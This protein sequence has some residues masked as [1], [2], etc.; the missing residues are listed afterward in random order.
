M[1]VLYITFRLIKWIYNNKTLRVLSISLIA[2][3]IVAKIIN[4]HF[5]K[6]MEFIQSEVYPHLYLIKNPVKD[7][8]LLKKAIK[9]MVVEKMNAEFIG[10]EEKYKR[11]YHYANKS[12]TELNYGFSFMEY[13]KGWGFNPIGEAGTAHFIKN[14]ED[15]GGFSSEYL[16]YYRERFQIGGMRVNYC[17]N[18]TIN[19]TAVL[20]YSEN[21]YVVERDTLINQCK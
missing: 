16:E 21:G 14:K 13:Y 4:N 15:P 9:E 17:K 5:F 3:F 7:K 1:L 11:R 18:D 6:K 10:N 19:Y 12:E 20:Y 8:A 2:L